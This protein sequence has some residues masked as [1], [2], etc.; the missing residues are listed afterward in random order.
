MGRAAERFLGHHL[1]RP[2]A[3]G[4]FLLQVG[5]DVGQVVGTHGFLQP[6]LVADG[7]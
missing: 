4:A 5:A 7:T 2:V 1:E 6:G 3:E